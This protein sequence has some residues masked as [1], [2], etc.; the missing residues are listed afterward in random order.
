M[1]AGLAKEYEDDLK[2]EYV[3]V[4]DLLPTESAEFHTVPVYK[5][6]AE[7]GSVIEIWTGTKTKAEIINIIE[8]ALFEYE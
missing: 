2:I 6:F 7:N 5:L 1:L 8:M 3:N 4:Y